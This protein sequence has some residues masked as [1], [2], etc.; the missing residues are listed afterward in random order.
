MKLSKNKKKGVEL[1]ERVAS[2]L[3][4]LDYDVIVRD[5][6]RGLVVKR[7]YEVDVHAVKRRFLRSPI[8]IWVECKDIKS[9]IKRTHIMKLVESARDVKDAE[10]E[11]VAEWAPDILMIV[12]TSGFDIDAI[13][14]ADKYGVYCVLA[15][16]RGY[17][18]VG[19]MAREDFDKNVKSDY[20]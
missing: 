7:P 11:G 18:F 9:N 17:I 12:A 2:W 14:F 20:Y 15:K 19:E 8:H 13:R 1:E 4:G 5:L 3:R 10:M 6:V 16:K